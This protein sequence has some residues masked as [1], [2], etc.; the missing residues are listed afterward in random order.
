MGLP[1]PKGIQ[2]EVLDLPPRGHNVILGTAGSGKT[3]LAIWRSMYLAK[4]NKNEK[5]LLVTFNTTLVKYLDAIAGTE[6]VNVDVR[7]YHKFARGYLN[8]K[9]LIPG[10]RRIV[11]GIE[12][13]DNKKLIIVREAIKNVIARIGSN[14]TLRR[15][16][17]IFLE[18]ISWIE[19]MGISTLDEY[20]G[21]ER[22]GRANTRI[23]RENRKFFFEVY[24]EYLKLRK[25]QGY[26]YDWDDIATTV[27]QTLIN[28][29]T[30]RMYKHIVIDE[31]QD[32]SPMMLRSLAVSIPEDGSLTF[33]G[34]VAQQ[35]YGGRISW[36]DAGLKI[37]KNK[38]WRFDRNYRNSKEIAEFALELSKS[39]YYM[40]ESDLVEPIMPTAS[41]PKPAVIRFQD[42]ISELE[43][44]VNNATIASQNQQ[45]AI[46][47]RDRETVNNVEAALRKKGI[48]PQV[49]K[50]SMPNVNTMANLSIG[51]YHS[52]KGFEFDFVFLPFCSF[53]RIPNEERVLACEGREEALKDEIKLLYVAVTRTKQRLILSYTGEKSDLLP[54]S[55]SEL[56]I[57]RE[58]GRSDGNK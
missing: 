12:D 29:G 34:D 8:S 52:A 46:L 21:L 27:Y 49:L 37:Q 16:E 20:E 24:T 44:I 51:T 31:G 36:R 38:I 53:A 39:K 33:F 22:V 10:Y 18:E 13:G 35:I 48:W 57:E 25:E 2:L 56:Y 26:L 55:R 23:N 14:S 45:V 11:S 15:N 19:K 54:E 30:P 17:N 6:L 43:W 58:I 28:D 7:N 4:L 50:S 5:V 3:T 41:S 1:S 32:L 47:V 9:G 40:N 42:E